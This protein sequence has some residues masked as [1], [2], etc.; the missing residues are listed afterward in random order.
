VRDWL[1]VIFTKQ[2]KITRPPFRLVVIVA[3][4]LLTSLQG[5][6]RFFLSLSNWTIYTTL[7]V[8]PGVW[9]LTIYGFFTGCVY[10]IAAAAIMF[11]LKKFKEVSTSFLLLGMAG[12]WF[13]RIFAASSPEAR[14]SLPFALISSGGL[15]IVAIGML[16][17]DTIVRKVLK[18]DK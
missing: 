1:D 6:I 10:L 7:G 14:T 2:K 15:T 16:Y 13:D 8:F 11:S 12:L 17:W 9:Y 5:W 18:Q 4:M 3:G